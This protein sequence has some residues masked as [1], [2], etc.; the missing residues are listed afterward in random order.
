[1]IKTHNQASV[2]PKKKKI[3]SES[4]ELLTLQ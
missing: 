3:K 1:M 2:E 4:Q